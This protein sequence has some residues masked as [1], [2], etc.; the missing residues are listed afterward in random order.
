MRDLLEKFGVTTFVG[1][2][3]QCPVE[4]HLN[5]GGDREILAYFFRYAFLRSLSDASGCTSRRS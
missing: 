5:N 3:S 1:M 2:Q 4:G